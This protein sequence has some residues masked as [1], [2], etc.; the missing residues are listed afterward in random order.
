MRIN[1]SLPQHSITILTWYSYFHAVIILLFIITKH[2]IIECSIISMFQQT[3]IPNNESVD[4]ARR[5]HCQSVRFLMTSMLI[6]SIQSIIQGLL[7]LGVT[8]H[9]DGNISSLA[10][11]KSHHQ[12]QRTSCPQDLD[13]VDANPMDV[14]GLTQTVDDLTISLIYNLALSFHLYGLSNP[15]DNSDYKAKDLLMEAFCLYKEVENKILNHESV[16]TVPFGLENNILHITRHLS[17]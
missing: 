9:P 14:F 2:T 4:Y 1:V 8:F 15:Q 3:I 11:F 13:I 5:C 10:S 17:S 6:D 16:F 12:E 7:A